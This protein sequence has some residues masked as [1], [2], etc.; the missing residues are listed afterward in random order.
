MLALLLMLAS[1]G[2]A[3]VPAPIAAGEDHYFG[4]DAHMAAQ[5]LKLQADGRY[6]MVDVQHRYTEVA[7]TGRWRSEGHNLVLESE[8]V[9]RDIDL[10]EFQVY[11]HNECAER[12]LPELRSVLQAWR[13]E[14]R[15]V[16]A[17]AMDGLQFPTSAH[18]IAGDP[19]QRCRVSFWYTPAEGSADP[20]PV[21]RLDPVLAGIDRWLADPAAQRIHEYGAWRYRRQQFLVPLRPG[22][23]PGPMSAGEVRKSM[24]SGRGERAAFVYYAIS[25]QQFA[26]AANCT[27]PFKFVEAMNKP[28]NQHP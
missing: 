1:T 25:A 10:G 26:K 22:M 6:F 23:G 13:D 3:P 15:P 12:V 11:V 5:Y 24:D 9:P 14:G 20:V 28:C 19:Q 16:P 18:P 8:R 7:D 21:A 4:Y 2:Q 27:Y 17:K